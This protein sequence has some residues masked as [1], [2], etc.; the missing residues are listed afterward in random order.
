MQLSPRL[1]PG[2]PLFISF[3]LALIV[4]P[5]SKVGAGNL[6]VLSSQYKYVQGNLTADKDADGDQGAA[7]GDDKG[8]DGKT[9]TSNSPA[10]ARLR[11]K[12]SAKSAIV[13]DATSGTVL[14]EYNADTQRQ[15][16]STIKVLTGL[17]AIERLNDHD[18]VVASRKAARMP[19]SKVYLKP[20]STYQANDLINAVLLASANDASVA[21]AEKIGGDESNFAKLMTQKA[22]RFGARNTVCK[23]ASGLT[24][25]GQH[26][27]ARDLAM[28]FNH[29]MHNQEFA[30]RMKHTKV[31][32]SFGKTLWNH[33]KALW[34]IA[35]AEGGKT[36]Y[37]RAARQ[38]YVGKFEKGG[39]ELI[40]AIMGSET[41][42]D[43]ISRLVRHGFS[44]ERQLAQTKPA[45]GKDSVKARL[46][47]L[48]DRLHNEYAND[49][50]PVRVLSEN[51]KLSPQL[52]L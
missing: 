50:N 3:L 39:R 46:A 37:T 8:S 13:L 4:L 30:N 9:L 44:E 35:G 28:V 27:T 31:I 7:V 16:A 22:K 18:H 26:T 52:S 32:T 19:R 24:K 51:N 41:M 11:R 43:D 2:I 6:P 47:K 49:F 34:R 23:T 10:D 40:V 29:A 20:G 48:K 25:R 15:P 36:G 42:W 33:N 12:L 21:L 1:N 38:T 5:A 17:I 14:Y 45:H